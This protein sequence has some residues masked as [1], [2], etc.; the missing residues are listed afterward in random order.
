MVLLDI[1]MNDINGISIAKKIGNQTVF[2]FTTAYLKY[3]LD[4]FDLDA[5][6][7]LHK[8]FSFDRF[9]T[10]MDKAL[11]RIQYKESRSHRTKNIVVKQEYANVS[12]LIDDIIYIEA[13]ENY[14]KIYN[15]AGNCI[16]SHNS[17][18]NLMTLL[19]VND[20]MRIH[21]SFIVPLSEITTFTRQSVKLSSGIVLPVGRQY[22]NE[23]LG[24]LSPTK[25]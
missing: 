22:V 1:E 3:A 25:T 5:V 17:M 4:G 23:L 8:P 24:R 11:R 21:R 15:K 20:F 18:K 10:A 16:I 2:I 7:F 9:R 12:V 13:M 19:P 6:D 14:T